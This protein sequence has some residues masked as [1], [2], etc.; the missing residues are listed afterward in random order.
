MKVYICFI[1]FM[2]G[3]YFCLN[4][5]HHDLVESFEN[6]DVSKADPSIPEMCPNLL[7]QKG[8]EYHLVNT[9]KA[10]IP[11][12]N[13]IK[14][15][16]LGEYIEYAKWQ[17]KM[18]NTCPV[19]YFQQT[20]DTQGKRAYRL[21]NDPLENRGGIRSEL[22]HTPN[23]ND[24]VVDASHDHNP[25]N[26]N[27]YSGFDEQNQQIGER[28][29]LDKKFKVSGYW[30]PMQS[31]WAGVETSESQAA[32][33]KPDRT[34]SVKELETNMHHKNSVDRLDTELNNL[35]AYNSRKINKTS[36][37]EFITADQKKNAL[38]KQ[39]LKQTD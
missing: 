33:F 26:K 31:D 10:M 17:E 28:T 9:K 5:T 12:V 35:R 34:R 37:Q 2:I 16:D 38:I 23:L 7:V 30:N 8:S 1:I 4:Y 18:Q 21:L 15:K 27:S 32:L 24:D 11:G 22:L 13:P 36:A 29:P 6:Y 19:L 25:F 39:S 14:F 20:F 3:L